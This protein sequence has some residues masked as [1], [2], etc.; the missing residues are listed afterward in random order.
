M[1]R[2]E[3]SAKAG[4]PRRRAALPAGARRSRKAS[5]GIVDLLV[6]G[7]GIAGLSAALEAGR[8]G[9]SVTLL[10]K[11]EDPAE[12]NTLY[13]QGGI[14][15][16]GID[17]SPGLFVSDILRAGAGASFPEAAAILASEGPRVVQELLIDMAGVEFDQTEDGEID[18]TA[19]AAHS[20]R[21]IYHRRDATGKEIEKKLL[22]AVAR[23]PR[24]NL[25]TAQVGIDL[26]T[27]A[28]HSM[29]RT[30]VYQPN[31]CLG[32]YVFDSETATV[33]THLARR[34]LLATGGIGRIY[35]HTT[36]PA[37]ATGDGIA[38]AHRAGAPIVNAEY[39]QFHPTAL[40]HRDAGRFLISEAVRGEGG[41]LVDAAGKPFMQRYSPRD[42]DLAPRDV[43]ARAIHEEMARTGEPCVFL[44]IARFRPPG[45]DIAARFPTI[46]AACRRFGIDIESE[47]IPVV[48]AA[49]YFCG[50]VK[51]DAW[52]QSELPGLFAAGE[53]ACT[54]LHGANRLASTSLLEGLVW[55]ARAIRRIVED[56]P[57]EPP[58][59]AAT[60]PPWRDEG[61]SEEEDPV[62]ISQDLLTVQTTMWNYAGIVRTEKRLR[63]AADDMGYLHRRV[64][65]F[66]RA[67]KLTR[68]LIEL[69]NAVLTAQLVIEAALRNP[70][71]RGCHFRK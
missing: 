60:I 26:I 37:T 11:M 9:L 21:R 31:V 54:G 3:P 22:A 45:L 24:I 2:R 68:Q 8:A 7:T 67:T 16:R 66:Y 30:A 46:A 65:D 17:D 29:E 58:V 38:M 70:E 62:L 64:M 35:L 32:A 55:G 51:V 5:P 20:R 57:V 47:P 48:P 71:S 13:A 19:E 36:N 44:D 25:L 27:S 40:F 28:H 53:V 34:T 12:S 1:T 56:G 15:V 4:S 6:I 63:R 18:L 49:H 10:S 69:R 59:A 42:R 14:A 41:R 61:L 23:C 43:V 39:V 52:G 50:G 33:R